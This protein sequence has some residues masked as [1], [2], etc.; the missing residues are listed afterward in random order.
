ALVAPRPPIDRRTV[1]REERGT[2][3][4]RPE[5][6]EQC[7]RALGVCRRLCIELELVAEDADQC[8]L[9]LEP[10]EIVAAGFG[11]ERGFFEQRPGPNALLERDVRIARDRE[12]GSQERRVPEL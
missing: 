10:Q 11:R 2:P 4:I 7:L 9:A 3:G 8:C 6:L 1:T 5:A 12:R